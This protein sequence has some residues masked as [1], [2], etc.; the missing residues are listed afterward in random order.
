MKIILKEGRMF[1][2]QEIYET[3]DKQLVVID[4]IDMIN[5]TLKMRRI[6]TPE[7]D[8]TVKLIPGKLYKLTS[9]EIIKI[10]YIKNGMVKYQD[11]S[12]VCNVWIPETNLKKYHK[13]SHQIN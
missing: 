7:D 11:I 13:I 12:D 2:E 4:K 1:K 8:S 10:I 6:N 5:N 3:T 9:G